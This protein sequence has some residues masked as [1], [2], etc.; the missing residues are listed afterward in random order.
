MATNVCIL[1]IG[2]ESDTKDQTILQKF[3]ELDAIGVTNEESVKQESINHALSSVERKAR[4]GLPQ[5][6][7]SDNALTFKKASREVQS[8]WKILRSRDIQDYCGSQR[9]TWKFIIEKAAWWGG[10]WERMVKSMKV[11]LRNVLGR[12]SLSF[13]EL[14]TVLA[15]VEAAI[16]SRPFTYV[17][18]EPAADINP[19]WRYRRSLVNAFWNRW[20]REYLLQLRSAHI[21]S[22]RQDNSLTVDDI[23]IV[24]EDHAQ[25]HSGKQEESSKFSKAV[26]E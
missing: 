2:L 19:R 24:H 12:Q 23:V 8:L 4:R 9:I 26:T 14:T 13:E 25:P 17:L 6:I 15:D 3:C 1:K 16:N 7:Y 20:Q 22:S 5:T 21:I 10:W 11:S 18:E